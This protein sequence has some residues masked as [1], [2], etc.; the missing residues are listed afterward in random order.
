MVIKLAPD[1][2]PIA[3]VSPYRRIDPRYPS[4]KTIITM[5]EVMRDGSRTPDPAIYQY[6]FLREVFTLKG[7]V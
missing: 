6:D 3:H 1:V 2:T 4:R 5:A 7:G